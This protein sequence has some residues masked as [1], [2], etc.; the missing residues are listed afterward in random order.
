[1]T[2]RIAT[3]AE[4]RKHFID[5]GHKVRIAKDGHVTFKR[6]GA[7]PWLEGRWVEEYRVDTDVEFS[8][9]YQTVRLT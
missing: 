2:S 8:R 3:D 7:G 9:V 6:D 4:I 5:A 1:M